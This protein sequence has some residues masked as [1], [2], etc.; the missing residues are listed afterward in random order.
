[1]QK[2]VLSISRTLT[3]TKQEEKYVF[4]PQMFRLLQEISF[5]D[6]EAQYVETG[7]VPKEDF[8]KIKEAIPKSAYATWLLKHISQGDIKLEDAYKY[9][10]YFDVFRRHKSEYPSADIFSYKTSRQ[11]S[12]FI[13]LS[14]DLIEKEQKDPSQ[15][16]GV[17]KEEKFK[18]LEIGE[19][20]GFTVYMIPKGRKDLKGVA[21]ELGSGTEWCTADE[22]ASYFEDYIDQGPLYI[23][24]KGSEKYQFHYETNQFMDKYDN[25]V[26]GLELED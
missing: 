7:K 12:E 14:V 9:A 1:M 25:P 16:K 24:T 5:E 26:F 13:K 19:V 8:E 23:F 6:L 2:N 17:E 10:K 3:E 4:S 20:E 22:R 15:K 18:D 11:I 21:C